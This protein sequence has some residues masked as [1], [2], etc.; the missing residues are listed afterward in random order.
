MLTGNEVGS[1]VSPRTVRTVGRER[2]QK[3]VPAVGEVESPA[4]S[5]QFR[6]PG[7]GMS[8][9]R[10]WAVPHRRRQTLADDTAAMT[11]GP[12]G[13]DG[14]PRTAVFGF[15][16]RLRAAPGRRQRAGAPSEA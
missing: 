11:V 14:A 6:R 15:S 13:A 1:D 4:A 7:T 16:V 5:G 12:A 3:A 2:R 9:D 8:G 10:L